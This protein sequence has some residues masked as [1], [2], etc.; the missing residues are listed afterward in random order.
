MTF[1]SADGKVTRLPPPSKRGGVPLSSA[2][3]PGIL[4]FI[5]GLGMIYWSLA[6]WGLFGLGEPQTGTPATPGH[7][8]ELNI[9]DT[10]FG[11]R[12]AG[13]EF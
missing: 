13:G 6:G 12:G 8:R 7:S 10:I 3:T 2:A 11:G 9:W 5:L 1:T 4:M